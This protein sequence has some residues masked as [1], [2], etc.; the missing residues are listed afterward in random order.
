M[1]PSGMLA[2]AETVEVVTNAIK[3][4]SISITIVDPVGRFIPFNA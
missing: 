2:S 3:H 4:H 1:A